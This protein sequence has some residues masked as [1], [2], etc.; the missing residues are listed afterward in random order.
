ME[1]LRI[2]DF[3]NCAVQRFYGTTESAR[4]KAWKP[5]D[6]TKVK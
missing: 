1:W 6:F 5:G 3:Q 4:M 2:G